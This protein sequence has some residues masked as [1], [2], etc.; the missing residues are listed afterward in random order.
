MKLDTLTVHNFKSYKDTHVLRFDQFT[1]I[2]GPNGSG[3]SN[4][5]DSFLFCF[6]FSLAKLRYF[7]SEG[8][9][10]VEVCFRV[11]GS[12]I[13]D[14][15][16]FCLDFNLEFQVDNESSDKNKNE[17]GFVSED[18]NEKSK[19]E[20]ENIEG[21][22]NNRD[23]NEKNV[24]KI[25]MLN[26]DTKQTINSF[27]FVR[28]RREMRN[29]KSAYYVNNTNVPK[30]QYLQLLKVLN[31]DITKLLVQQ[32]E[33]ETISLKKPLVML[34]YLEKSIGTHILIPIIEELT[35]KTSNLEENF[36]TKKAQYNFYKKEFNHCV[37]QICGVYSSLKA[38][39]D[40]FLFNLL[41]NVKFNSNLCFN[42]K[43]SNK[44]LQ[45]TCKKLGKLKDENSASKQ[46]VSL[47]ESDVSI[48]K[49]KV[50]EKEAEILAV[51][52]LVY[53]DE[54]G[55]FLVEER[56]KKVRVNVRNVEK[57]LE[58]RVF[59]NNEKE[60]E[61]CR[62]K[63]EIFSNESEIKEFQR[64]VCDLIKDLRNMG[65]KNVQQM[66]L[67]SIIEID[68]EIKNKNNHV[69]LIKEDDEYNIQS[70]YSEMV[71]I[72]CDIQNLQKELLEISLIGINFVCKEVNTR[73]V[74]KDVGVT[75]QF[76]E[77][78]DSFPKN[79]PDESI[80]TFIRN[81][82]KFN[83]F[84]LDKNNIQESNIE[85]SDVMNENNIDNS[86]DEE[87]NMNDSNILDQSM[88]DS[89]HSIKT[90]LIDREL[91]QKIWENLNIPQIKK[92]Y[93]AQT[94]YYRNSQNK[95]N[96]Y[97]KVAAQLAAKLQEKEKEIQLKESITSNTHFH[98][99]IH[100]ALKN[101]PNYYGRIGTLCSTYKEYENACLSCAKSNLNNYLVKDEKTAEVCINKIRN[102]G[103]VGFVCLDRINVSMGNKFNKNKSRTGDKD[104]KNN[105]NS[106][107]DLLDNSNNKYGKHLDFKSNEKSAIVDF[108]STDM[109]TCLLLDCIEYEK[110]YS[111]VFQ[112]VFGSTILCKSIEDAKKIAFGKIRKKT[113]TLKGELIEKTGLMCGYFSAKVSS[114][115]I[116]IKEKKLDDASISENDNVLNASLESNIDEI[117][118]IEKND[119]RQFF[120]DFIDNFG[121]LSTSDQIKDEVKKLD[122]EKDKFIDEINVCKNMIS[123][124]DRRLLR[125]QVIT[126]E[127][128]TN[129][130][131]IISG[132][133]DIIA[134]LNDAEAF[135]KNDVV[136]YLKTGDSK[137]KS[138]E[139][140]LKNHIQDDIETR[141]SCLS[142]FTTFTTS[143][144]T[145]YG[146]FKQ[147]LMHLM[148]T[149]NHKI[150]LNKL[151]KL[152]NSSKC[153]FNTNDTIKETIQ[154]VQ[155]KIKQIN[156][157]KDKDEPLDVKQ[158]KSELEILVDK[159]CLLDDRNKI[160][161]KRLENIKID[162]V[163]GLKDELQKLTIEMNDLEG[164]T[165]FNCDI[166]ITNKDIDKKSP[167]ANNTCVSENKRFNKLTK[168]KNE[169][170]K[171]REKLSELKEE[172][173]TMKKDLKEMSS[174]LQILKQKLGNDFKK[175][176]ELKEQINEN[177]DRIRVY[178]NTMLDTNNTIDKYI[179]EI[180]N[181]ISILS[182]I[183]E[184]LFG[185][186]NDLQE[187]QSLS[188]NFSDSEETNAKSN[189]SKSNKVSDIKN[190]ISIDVLDKVISEASVSFDEILLIHEMNNQSTDQINNISALDSKIIQNDVNQENKTDSRSSEEEV[191]E[192]KDSTNNSISG[193]NKNILDTKNKKKKNKKSKDNNSSEKET[194]NLEK[195]FSQ[196]TKEILDKIEQTTQINQISATQSYNIKKHEKNTTQIDTSTIQEFSQKKLDF[197]TQS[198]EYKN[199]KKNLQSLLKQLHLQKEKRYNMFIHGLKKINSYLKT[200]YNEITKG[201]SAELEPV[202]YDPFQGIILSIRPPKKSWKKLD[203]LSGGEKTMASI[204]LVMAVHQY[205]P[206]FFYL[207]DEIDAALDYRN[208]CIVAEFIK[209]C[210]LGVLKNSHSNFYIPEDHL[211]INQII[212]ITQ[213]NN[214]STVNEAFGGAQ[215]IIVSLRSGF[216]EQADTLVGVF[217]NVSSKTVTFDMV[218]LKEQIDKNIKV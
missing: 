119:V 123:S 24:K 118:Q 17:G 28:L 195:N 27:V 107:N 83:K 162:D 14:L 15:K 30:T 136:K 217:K 51:Q 166:N 113:V 18:I 111:K 146:H 22:E 200:I 50:A 60:N 135:T 190:N 152:I 184:G 132:C 91:I 175:E 143:I 45:E 128:D 178:K 115:I 84:D 100:N 155:N 157:E 104:D 106:N 160:L 53:E 35:L 105:D 188:E 75:K 55:V 7:N 133:K 206:S 153:I 156:E 9:C 29:G 62:V 16:S 67:P 205:K 59:R 63:S 198:K 57:I 165:G 82:K 173:N 208:T 142:A 191:T 95:L 192:E 85:C 102:I 77:I 112:F 134:M 216:I 138:T 43:K 218:S 150:I 137:I 96:S 86:D 148:V 179:E 31:I 52:S 70:K 169:L 3:K 2:V 73:K 140:L 154:R 25:S 13:D 174:E 149:K 116:Q 163:S 38:N 199:Y 4:I 49:K 158:K 40:S 10:Y 5:L 141:N 193:E 54:K 44:N 65:V 23:I 201:G 168:L 131:I 172:Y 66:V 92:I 36:A 183:K 11:G 33:I 204:A 126:R 109:T 211:N 182:D 210:S 203:V 167:K 72:G 164:N 98:T 56:V 186:L 122:N 151:K 213:D 196:K 129:N 108:I 103:R 89:N 79:I 207:L 39:L 6:G 88:L 21:I 93:S 26:N 209:K 8:F 94:E 41:L 170:S 34:E 130:D 161:R 177:K 58:E 214:T 46:E 68:G 125:L 47:R 32:G 181:L 97:I 147:N 37:T 87:S 12:L 81:I 78:L 145:E 139:N 99:K 80:S 117:K 101:V 20:I 71:K 120:L 19:S 90:G 159:V 194:Y 202:E 171:K 61:I 110:K 69:N 187:D 185:N 1:C 74:E 144:L 76:S 124:I 215:F 189:V 121:N 114:N 127:I 212:N 176:V 197:K 48:L 64:K 180:K 42:L